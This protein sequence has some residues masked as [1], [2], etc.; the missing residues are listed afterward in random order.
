MGSVLP[1]KDWQSS[2]VSLYFGL[3]QIDDFV[4]WEAYGGGTWS[5]APNSEY[6]LT[7]PLGETKK[8]LQLTLPVQGD[9]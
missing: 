4:S 6:K 9:Q 3:Q 5:D 7:L 1:A 2:E 8:W